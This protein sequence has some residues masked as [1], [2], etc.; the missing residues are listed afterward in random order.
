MRIPDQDRKSPIEHR[1]AQIPRDLAEDFCQMVEDLG[2]SPDIV[3]AD[4][5]PLKAELLHCALG[6]TGE[7]SEVADSVKKYAIYGQTLDTKN[8]VEEL[9]DLEFY[10]ERTRQALGITR[11]DTIRENVKKLRKRY[12]SGM[13]T[14]PD[15]ARRADKR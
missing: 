3:K 2:Q 13:F 12:P 15:S 8:V 10:L 14:T 1:A 11:E 7:A 9:G 4:M 6:L 5:T